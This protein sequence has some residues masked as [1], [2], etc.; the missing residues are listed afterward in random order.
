[1]VIAIIFHYHTKVSFH[2]YKSANISNGHALQSVLHWSVDSL[3]VQLE[4]CVFVSMD[5]LPWK[6]YITSS[7]ENFSV[8]VLALYIS[9]IAYSNHGWQ[10][11]AF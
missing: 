11:S 8:T 4:R 7:A 10:E 9:T 6:V 1:M 2:Y 5:I 3:I